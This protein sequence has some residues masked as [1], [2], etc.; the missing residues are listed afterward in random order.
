MFLYLTEYWFPVSQRKSFF[1]PGNI[2]VHFY[3]LNL[4][5][6]PKYPVNKEKFSVF[7]NNLP[8]SKAKMLQK[9]Y[10]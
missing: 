4:S 9:S 3:L 7:L 8:N 5:I 2:D 6:K 10:V 1:F